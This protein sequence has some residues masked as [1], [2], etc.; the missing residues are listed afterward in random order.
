MLLG[1][2]VW[3]ENSKFLDI[4]INKENLKAARSY[5]NEHNI[6][7]EV[8]HTNIQ[9]LIDAVELEG[10]KATLAEAGSRTSKGH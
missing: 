2:V 10:I 7:K 4:S 5:L 1:G 9:E 3:K 6:D 8:V